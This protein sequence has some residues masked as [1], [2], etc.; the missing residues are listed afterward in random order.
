MES[1]N[2]KVTKVGGKETDSF[3]FVFLCSKG[4]TSL[5]R[6]L[7][8]GNVCNACKLLRTRNPFPIPFIYSIIYGMREDG[9]GC[10]GPGA[11][12]KESV[13]D[14]RTVCAMVLD[15]CLLCCSIRWI[16][17]M[18]GVPRRVTG[19]RMGHWPL[20]ESSGCGLLRNGCGL[21]L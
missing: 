4:T 9:R 19:L 17:V 13:F 12:S 5:V 2:N 14:P 7:V 21:I 6:L 3:F 15:P 18:E 20:G 11:K 8:H 16:E 10:A 1:T